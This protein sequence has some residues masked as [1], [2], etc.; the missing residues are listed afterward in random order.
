MRCIIRKG[1]TLRYNK[2]LQKDG[3]NRLLANT[4][5]FDA[6]R[7]TLHRQQIS[8]FGQTISGQVP[9][10]WRQIV[11]TIMFII[12]HQVRSNYFVKSTTARRPDVTR[13]SPRHNRG[14]YVVPVRWQPWYLKLYT[15]IFVP[16]FAPLNYSKSMMQR[17]CLASLL[18]SIVRFGA[19]VFSCYTREGS[20]THFSIRPF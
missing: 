14:N 10:R 19:W 16:L 9:S 17:T 1:G 12:T 8:F 11:T 15:Q 6:S 4:K 18:F 3:L 5:H 7:H 2:G 13:K 20:G